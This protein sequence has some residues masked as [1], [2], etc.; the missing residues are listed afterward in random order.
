LQLGDKV[1]DWDDGFRLYMV[2]KL[3]NPEYSAELAGRTMIINYSVTV[4]GLEDQLLDVVVDN[5][6]PDLQQQREELIQ[7][8]SKNSIKLA[9]LEAILLRV[10]S[11]LTIQCRIYQ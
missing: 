6:R 7:T 2:T 11:C 1:I 3:S 10:I 4:T 8:M 9:E 5:E